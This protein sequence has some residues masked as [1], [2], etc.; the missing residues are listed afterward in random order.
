MSSPTSHSGMRTSRQREDPDAM[1]A[2]PKVLIDGDAQAQWTTHNNLSQWFDD[3]KHDLLA[4]TTLV[5]DK[6]AVCNNEGELVSE[7]IQK[8]CKRRIINMDETH[9]DL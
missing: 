7:S 5:E 2:G 1:Q 9:Y 4:A 8:D 3:E 6:Q